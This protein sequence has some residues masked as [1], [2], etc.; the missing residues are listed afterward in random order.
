MRVLK[1]MVLLL[2]WQGPVLADTRCPVIYTGNQGAILNPGE[3]VSSPDVPV[4]EPSGLFAW[5][6]T[7]QH[8]GYLL[9][10]EGDASKLHF[11]LLWH[12]ALPWQGS[13]P[14]SS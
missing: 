12:P 1:L 8:D 5:V 10:V 11:N 14:D 13:S 9:P 6:K 2:L 4:A 7:G 3:V